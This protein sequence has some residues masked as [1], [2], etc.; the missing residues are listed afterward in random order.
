VSFVED[1]L[2]VGLDASVDKMKDWIGIREK[3]EISKFYE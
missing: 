2:N 3:A 1:V